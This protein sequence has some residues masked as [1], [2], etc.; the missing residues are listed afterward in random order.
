VVQRPRHHAPAGNGG[1]R[2]V[3]PTASVAVRNHL[4]RGT[5]A[6]FPG[7]RLGAARSV[8]AIA[9]ANMP[10]AGSDLDGPKRAS[11]AYR[12]PGAGRSMSSPWFAG[13]LEN[14]PAGARPA[15]GRRQSRR[16]CLIAMA[17]RGADD[18]GAVD[19]WRK[20][21]L[22]K[23]ARRRRMD[24]W[25]GRFA[26]LRRPSDAAVRGASAD[27]DR[28]RGGSAQSA[29]RN[30][31]R[32]RATSPVA[33]AK[34]YARL[35]PARGAGVQARATAGR[36]YHMGSRR[37]MSATSRS[38]GVWGQKRS[39]RDRDGSTTVRARPRPVLRRR[40]RKSSL[41]AVSRTVPEL[42]R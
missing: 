21:G 6:V 4:F 42:Y 33:D 3:A 24:R 37:A 32:A 41:K 20:M 14:R 30:P 11:G 35:T 18:D 28:G 17:E 26:G 19:E 31:E 12:F 1:W 34:S 15:Q 9:A 36:I 29:S 40:R 38:G 5:A 7:D 27:G 8:D 22:F 16:F 13:N 23:D 25:Q 10:G 39:W 2:C